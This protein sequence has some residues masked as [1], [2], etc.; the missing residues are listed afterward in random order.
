MGID[1]VVELLDYEDKEL[2]VGI[3]VLSN[4][5]DDLLKY[6]SI[7]RNSKTIFRL[8]QMDNG[9][10]LHSTYIYICFTYLFNRKKCSFN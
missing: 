10:M 4:S 7:L 3:A 2:V 8:I 6:S 5:S 9:N 1:R